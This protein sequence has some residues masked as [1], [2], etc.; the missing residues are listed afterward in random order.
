MNHQ[1]CLAI[2]LRSDRGGAR[3][4]PATREH[5]TA[6]EHVAHCSDCWA[7]LSV[8]HE[9][10]AGEPPPRAERMGALF[11]CRPVQDEMYLLTGLAAEEM[12]TRHPHVARHLGWCH[13]CRD[14]LAE[15]LTVERAAA[16]G[17]FGPPLIASAATRWREATA[18]I[19][20]TVREAVGRAVIQLRRAGAAF[21][22]VPE[23]FLVTPMA[24]PAGVLRGSAP[25]ETAVPALGQQV[26]FALPESRLSA[27]VTLEPHGPER[28]GMALRLSGAE[29]PRLSV[30]VREVRAEGLELVARHTVQ[31]AAPVVVRGL[32]PG[33]YLL[34]IE[35]KQTARRFQLRFDIESSA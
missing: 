19:G 1:E 23:G 8:L 16:R 33:Q 34:E 27:E 20:E 21:T 31:G 29:Q 7:V 25:V 28:V 6:E 5:R 4:A 3:G 30:H 35:D 13:A 18:R 26:R 32:A 24:A 12:R 10:A 22:A 17:E 2:L 14:R 15:V 9:L 11:G